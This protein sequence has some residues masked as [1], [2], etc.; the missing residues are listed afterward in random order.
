MTPVELSSFFVAGLNL[1]LYQMHTEKAFS[2]YTD[3]IRAGLGLMEIVG[4]GDVFAG[5]A[6][7][8]LGWDERGNCL[9]C[10]I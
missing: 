4:K 9:G 6:G 3:T 1:E 8:G 2:K 7:Q 10:K 5:G